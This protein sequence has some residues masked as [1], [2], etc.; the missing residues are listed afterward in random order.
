MS[1]LNV[2]NLSFQPS[3]SSHSNGSGVEN[4][5]YLMSNNTTS[6]RP[7]QMPTLTQPPATISSP[8]ARANKIISS[9]IRVPI[10]PASM[11]SLG[12]SQFSTLAQYLSTPKGLLESKSHEKEDT[13]SKSLVIQIFYL[14]LQLK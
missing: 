7:I 1:P 13:A 9:P 2:P 14:G 4:S 6:Y 12:R 3:I 10:L 11:T 8:T 5:A